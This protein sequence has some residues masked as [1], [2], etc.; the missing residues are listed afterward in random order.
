MSTHTYHALPFRELPVGAS[1]SR[2]KFEMPERLASDDQAV[3]AMTDLRRITALTVERSNTLLATRE[4]MKKLGVRM[5][6]VTNSTGAV[7]GVVTLTDL[8]SDRPRRIA[9]KTG[10]RADDL[11]VQDIM[12]L[13][14]R[15]EV[16][17]LVDVETARVGD[18]LATLLSKRRRHALVCCTPASTG[19]DEVC[20]VFSL[21]QTCKRVG[22]NV[23]PGDDFEL[24]ENELRQVLA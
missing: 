17:N 21:S 8:D 16:L 3:Q 14:G 20:G 11:Q 7:M 24:I 5:L 23:Q 19:D 22:L 2:P 15:I 12:T 6:L 9:E 4:R 18:I 1:Y 10:E 13:R